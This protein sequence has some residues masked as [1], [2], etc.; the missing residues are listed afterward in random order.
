M[1]RRAFL[2]VAGGLAGGIVGGSTTN[3][4]ANAGTKAGGNRQ[5]EGLPRRP[6]GS[7]GAKLSIVGFPGFAL[8]HYDQAESTAGVVR[9]FERGMNY[10]DVAPAYGKDGECEIKLG[11]ALQEVPREQIF[12][13]CKT[14]KR[15]K[16]GAREELERSLKRL[17]TDHFDLYQ[18]HCIF[19]P[20]EVE[21][22]LG[23]DGAMET[24]REAQAEGKIKHIGFSAHTTLG[25]LAALKGYRW[26][27]V[28]F[29]INY[30]EHYSFGFGKEVVELADQQGVSVI[31]IKATSGGA[32]PEGQ[33]RTRK[34]WYN[35]LEDKEDIGRA[36]R[37][38]LSQKRVV[39]A[40]PPSFLDLLDRTMD[41]AQKD[42]PITEEELAILQ[43]KA[44]DAPP[45]FER[46]QRRALAD[47]GPVH[48]GCMSAYT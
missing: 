14:K 45:V 42:V 29:P 38:A 9:A 37:F 1:K 41:V 5:K 22:I 3:Q 6:L 20:S 32:W 48:D 44:A 24:M 4:L 35:T 12:L 13:S 15:D 18:C 19:K 39:T 43:A 21:Q 34:W 10:Y 8:R 36:L 47:S 27:S 7:T 46:Q 17:K 30:V 16:K 33:A 28:M 23:P 2:K 40:I 31:A 11:V 25:A 26:D